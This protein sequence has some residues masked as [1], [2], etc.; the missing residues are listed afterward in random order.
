VLG[1]RRTHKY[2]FEGEREQ[3]ASWLLANPE[4]SS[5]DIFLEL[6]WLSSGD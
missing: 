2:P 6:P 5:G 3:I 4:R 1:W